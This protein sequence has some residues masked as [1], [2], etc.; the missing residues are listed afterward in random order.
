MMRMR[1]VAFFLL[2]VFVFTSL[3]PFSYARAQVLINE[4]LAD[5]ASDWDGDGVLGSKDDEW[6]EVLNAGPSSVD[7]S[8]YRLGDLSGGYSWRY[9]FSGALQ[10]GAV[11][12]VY[13]SDSEVWQTE[14]GFPVAGLSLNNTGDTVLLYR[15]EGT[16]TLVVDSYAYVSHEVVDD[17]STGRM[18][19]D[20]AEWR[21]FDAL[22]PYSGT[23]PP[24]GTGCAPSPG[25]VNACD[26]HVPI[27]ATTWGA[28][29]E[30]FVD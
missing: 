30:M 5:P 26:P 7:L 20:T 3:I 27:E 17:R 25:V 12:V 28:I 16:D 29:K 21:V 2:L 13:G 4:I 11:V 15:I 14:N 19:D 9:G 1:N 24:L 22:N 10:P 18:S 8:G 23:K 6:V